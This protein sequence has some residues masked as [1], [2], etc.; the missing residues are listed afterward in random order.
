M[1]IGNYLPKFTW[2]FNTSLTYKDFDF[3]LLIEGVHGN[4]VLNLSYMLA[5]TVIGESSSITLKDAE[6]YWTPTNQNTIW[7]VPTSSTRKE[8]ANSTKWIQDGSFVKLRNISIGYTTPK[9]LLKG[10]LRISLSA[11]NLFTI[12]PL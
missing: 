11:Q 1:I 9:T 7:A 12:T 2:G 3:N 10:Q 4:D 5:G 6:N 8:K